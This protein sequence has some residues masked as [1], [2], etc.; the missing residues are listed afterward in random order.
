MFVLRIKLDRDL[1]HIQSK[2]F[3]GNNMYTTVQILYAEMELREKFFIPSIPSMRE[4]IFYGYRQ[5]KRRL[6]LK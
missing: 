2:L 4:D 6:K 5:V 1:I 3:D